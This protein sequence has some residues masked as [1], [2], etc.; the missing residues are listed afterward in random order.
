MILYIRFESFDMCR[1]IFMCI[2]TSQIHPHFFGTLK[3]Q[4]NLLRTWVDLPRGNFSYLQC[5]LDRENQQ[6]YATGEILYFS[7]EFS[8]H[9]EA[10]HKSFCINHSTHIAVVSSTKPMYVFRW[11]QIKAR[12]LLHSEIQCK[13]FVFDNWGLYFFYKPQFLCH[14][15][16]VWTWMWF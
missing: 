3:H 13:M 9:T 14:L 6:Q 4:I 7:C 12:R 11:I 10:N 8:I 2:Q 5:M 16:Y 15:M 1:L